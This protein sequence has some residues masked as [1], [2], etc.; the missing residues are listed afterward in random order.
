MDAKQQELERFVAEQF[1]FLVERGFRAPTVAK[2][3]WITRVDFVY[4][5]IASEVEV[6]WRELD[7]FVLLVRLEAGRLP[8]GYYVSRGRRSRVHLLTL[9][10]ERK[11]PADSQVV[12]RL[13]ASAPA[14]ARKSN[15]ADL[16]DKIS[17]YRALVLQCLERIVEES[18]YLFAQQE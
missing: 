15:I 6:H 11:W 14:G 5:S 16:E 17:A 7:I 4:D 1:A 10:A 18:E 2:E 12:S 13:H 3:G 9:V 8:Q